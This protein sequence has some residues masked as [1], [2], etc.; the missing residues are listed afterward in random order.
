[1]QGTIVIARVV[2]AAGYK[3]EDAL[4]ALA[5][6]VPLGEQPIQ[7]LSGDLRDGVPDRHVHRA[8]GDRPLAVAAWLFIHHHPIPDLRRIEIGSIRLEERA[9]LS[10][11][12]A[13]DESLA[14]EATLSVPAVGVEAVADHSPALAPDFGD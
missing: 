8:D 12:K 3:N 6:S 13:R 9:R 14:Q 10:F 11:Q 7:R 4:V 5:V 1:R 2:V